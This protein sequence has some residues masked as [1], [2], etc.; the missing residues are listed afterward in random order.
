M[1][2]ASHLC[3]QRVVLDLIIREAATELMQK[4]RQLVRV[5]AGSSEDLECATF[6]AHDKVSF[7]GGALS[8]HLVPCQQGIDMFSRSPGE[9]QHLSHA[10]KTCLF[11]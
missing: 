11:F 8:H 5:D 1:S 7:G 9:S 10:L 2:L 6:N 4:G 3:D